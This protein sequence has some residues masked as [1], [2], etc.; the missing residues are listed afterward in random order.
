MNRLLAAL[1][2]PAVAHAATFVDSCGDDGAGPTIHFKMDVVNRN[3]GLKNMV[4]AAVKKSSFHVQ[5]T[6]QRVGMSAVD[7]ELNPLDGAS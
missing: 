3:N 4:S 6:V 1:V 7:A 2:L 5:P